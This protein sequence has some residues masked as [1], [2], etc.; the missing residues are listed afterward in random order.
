MMTVSIQFFFFTIS[1]LY[2]RRGSV[3]NLSIFLIIQL[4]AVIVSMLIFYY[5]WGSTMIYDQYFYVV[6]CVK[7]LF[8]SFYLVIEAYITVKGK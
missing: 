8:L 1:S 6:F 3:I 2:R 4:T 5:E 7:F